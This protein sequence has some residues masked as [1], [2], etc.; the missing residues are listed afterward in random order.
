MKH[1]NPFADLSPFE[2]VLATREDAAYL[3]MVVCFVM[4]LAND[5]YGFFNWRRMARRQG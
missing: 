5:L 2:R 4:F 1:F 3:P